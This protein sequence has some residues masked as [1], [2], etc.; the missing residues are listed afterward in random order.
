MNYLFA[1]LF[2]INIASGII[3]WLDKRKAIQSKRRIKE[4]TL[5]FYELLGGVFSILFL[6]YQIRHKNQKK[7]YFLIT[8]LIALL[9]IGLVG[10]VVFKFKP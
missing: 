4:N 6:M 3:F 7:G 9:W 1:Y 10:F 8:Y 2:L 5:H